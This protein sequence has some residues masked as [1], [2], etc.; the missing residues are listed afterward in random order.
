M[1]KKEKM[2]PCK[3]AVIKKVPE[4]IKSFSRVDPDTYTAPIGKNLMND[5]SVPLKTTSEKNSERNIL[6]ENQN[7]NNISQ[8]I[9]SGSFEE[10]SK[11]QFKDYFKYQYEKYSLLKKSYQ[12]YEETFLIVDVYTKENIIQK[13]Q[14]RLGEARKLFKDD[15]MV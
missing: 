3:S 13:Y 1:R 5:T 11:D 7:Q 8:N 4:V 14:N 2:I 10:E 6:L 15:K 9:D 12:S